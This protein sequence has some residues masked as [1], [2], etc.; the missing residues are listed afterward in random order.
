M[1]KAEQPQRDEEAPNEAAPPK[2]PAEVL[3]EDEA[4]ER[5]REAKQARP[6][7]SLEVASENVADAFESLRDQV[8]YWANRGRYNKVRIKRKGKAVVPDIPVGA[9][10]AFEAATFF[11]TGILRAAIANVVGRVFFEVELVNEAEEH[12]REGLSYFLAGDLDDADKKLK[13]ALRIDPRFARAHLQMGVLRK[14]QGRHADA[15]THFQ[16]AKDND[17]K[18]EVGKEA[19]A[20]LKKLKAERR[21]T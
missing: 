9:L 13:E 15:R 11:W 7:F 16:K 17:P 19:S 10:L 20:H 1:A 4:E 12:Y 14:V 5:E 21:V 18:G 6:K 8:E 3:S 2:E